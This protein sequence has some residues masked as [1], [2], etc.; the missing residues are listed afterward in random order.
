MNDGLRKKLKEANVKLEEAKGIIEE[1]KNEEEEKLETM[2]D[3]FKEGEKGE[4]IQEGVD[5][6]DQALNG[7]EDVIAYVDSA[8][9]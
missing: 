9:E 6:L 3:S 4:K 5:N 1:V 2:P 7:L 8:A